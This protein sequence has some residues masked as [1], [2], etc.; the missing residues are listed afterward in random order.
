MGNHPAR[1]GQSRAPLLATALA[2]ILAA[3]VL[4]AQADGNGPDS[5]IVDSLWNQPEGVRPDSGWYFIQAWWDQAGL[6]LTLDPRQRGLTELGM[7][8]ADLLTAYSLL[9]EARTNPGPHP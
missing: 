2:I 5:A 4:P 7:A 3:T 6:V 9:A 1:R 8:N